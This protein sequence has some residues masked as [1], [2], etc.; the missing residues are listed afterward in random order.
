[1]GEAVRGVDLALDTVGG[2]TTASLL[3]A[4]RNG[5]FLANAGDD[6]HAVGSVAPIFPG[7]VGCVVIEPVYRSGGTGPVG[8]SQAG[9]VRV[10]RSG[11]G[12]TRVGESLSA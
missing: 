4:V 8:V 10:R 3:P 12:S 11:R 2:E 5:A 1:V 9:L 6:V 7:C